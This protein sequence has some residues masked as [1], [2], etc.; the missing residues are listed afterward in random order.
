MEPTTPIDCPDCDVA[1]NHH[2]DKLDLSM[3][4]AEPQAVDPALGGIVNEV[5]TCPACG[6]TA[7][8]RQTDT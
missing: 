4:L 6:K 5:H 1:M 2:A 3:A 8:R 7:I